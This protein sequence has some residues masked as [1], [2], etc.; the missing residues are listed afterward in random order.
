MYDPMK[1]ASGYSMQDNSFSMKVP[2]SGGDTEVSSTFDKVRAGSYNTKRRT[3]PLSTGTFVETNQWDEPLVTHTAAVL[4]E[5]NRRRSGDMQDRSVSSQHDALPAQST[6]SGDSPQRGGHL[7]VYNVSSPQVT[8][9][10]ASLLA[11]PKNINESPPLSEQIGP[12]SIDSLQIFSPTQ[13]IEPLFPLHSTS[14]DSGIG[15]Q[16]ISPT[17]TV[18]PIQQEVFTWDRVVASQNFLARPESSLPSEQQQSDPLTD[19]EFEAFLNV[20]SRVQDNGCS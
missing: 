3:S 10:S 9:V 20:L 12:Y 15:G 6:A 2:D 16:Q 13:S 18:S 11:H 19:E 8:A 1:V 17:Q 7:G 4:H 5:S 14:E